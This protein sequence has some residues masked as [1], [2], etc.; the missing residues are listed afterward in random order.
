MNCLVLG[1]SAGLG[2]AL[3]ERLAKDGHHLFLVASDSRDLQV[4]CADLKLRYSIRAEYEAISISATS[5]WS[6]ALFQAVDRFGKIDALYFPIGWASPSDD[7]FLSEKESK[8]IAEVNF[9][10]ITTVVSHF[11]P[12]LLKEGKGQVVGFGSIASLRGRK[13]NVIYSAMKRALESYF[14]SVRHLTAQ[15]QIRVQFYQIGYLDTQQTLGKKLLFPKCSPEN[16]AE[17]V[18]RNLNRDFG[19]QFLPRFWWVIA[20]ILKRVPWFLYKKLNF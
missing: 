15:T 7:G 10:C 8:Q 2:R 17:I 19:H 6:E 14:E 1:S 18:I 12:S 4:Q 9:H 13:G 16:A 20:F 11:L 5:P 3:S